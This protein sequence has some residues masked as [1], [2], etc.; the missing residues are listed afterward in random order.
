MPLYYRPA[1]VKQLQ[2][3]VRKLQ[4]AYGAEETV[5]E[6]RQNRRRDRFQ[7]YHQ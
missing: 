7:Q 2:D 6:K 4:L 5:V 1:A 3:A